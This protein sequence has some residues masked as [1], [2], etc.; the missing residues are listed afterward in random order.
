MF[1][2][3]EGKEYHADGEILDHHRG[4][5]LRTACLGGERQSQMGNLN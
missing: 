1:D 3:V 2:P 5:V 4:H